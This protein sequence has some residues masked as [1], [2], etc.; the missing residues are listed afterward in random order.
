MTIVVTSSKRDYTPR[1]PFSKTGSV[2]TEPP[3]LVL[4]TSGE[5]I[6]KIFQLI[7]ITQKFRPRVSGVNY[8]E[9]RDMTREETENASRTV[10]SDNVGFKV[11]FRWRDSRFQ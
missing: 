7:K 11:R 6:E 5:V 3:L 1:V 10:S 4:V 9:N 8:S 2:L